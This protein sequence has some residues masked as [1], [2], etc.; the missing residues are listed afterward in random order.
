MVSIRSNS[1]DSRFNRLSFVAPAVAAGAAGAAAAG[2]SITPTLI[3]AGGSLLAGGLGAL[4]SGVSG[5]KYLKGVRETNETNLQLARE[6]RDWDLAQWNRENEYNSAA[7]QMQRWQ[8][9]GMSPASFAGSPGEAASLQSP[10]MANQ[11]APGDLSGYASSMAQSI[12]QGVSGA[13]KAAMDWK[14][15]DINERQLE[16]DK[17]RLANQT[18]ETAS[19]V[20]LNDALTNE[21]R[22]NFRF[23]QERAR[24]TEAERYRSYAATDRLVQEWEQ[25]AKMFPV[26]YG[27]KEVTLKHSQLE[28][29]F[30]QKSFEYRLR[31]FALENG[32]TEAQT[33]KTVAEGIYW[34]WQ[35]KEGQF[36]Y[37]TQDLRWS[38]LS[39]Q[40]RQL[41]FNLQFDKDTRYSQLNFERWM[42]GIHAASEI[43]HLVIDGASEIRSWIHPG[44]WLGNFTT[45][46]GRNDKGWITD[47]TREFSPYSR[48]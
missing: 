8:A 18:S 30:A 45:H 11:V 29:L 36:Q 44:Q 5:S 17:Q 1:K 15:M 32:L 28:Y 33:R 37:D 48:F 27:D 14:Q 10:T 22:A 40:G 35:G 3:T 9:A 4:A 13:T 42:K 7:A 25:A 38:I 46:Y 43:G 12:Q 20:K 26:L 16:L 34:L 39:T 24:F 41:Q 31:Q 21:A 19:R 47:V 6:Q 2:S 23:I